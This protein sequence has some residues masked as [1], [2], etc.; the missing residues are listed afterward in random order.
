MFGT[1]VA[2]CSRNALSKRAA[3]VPR[4][5]FACSPATPSHQLLL[6]QSSPARWHSGHSHQHAHNA[7]LLNKV[8]GTPHQHTE[9]L[10]PLF[11]DKSSADQ[12]QRITILGF[13]SNVVLAAVKALA[14]MCASNSLVQLFLLSVVERSAAYPGFC[15]RFL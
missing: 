15:P 5:C 14:G 3:L 2:A 7:G 6:R 8:I 11:G 1:S 12:G 13:A 9:H 10:E 4:S